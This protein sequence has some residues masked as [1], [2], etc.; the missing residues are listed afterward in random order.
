MIRPNDAIDVYYLNYAIN[1]LSFQRE[2][3]RR[4]LSVAFPQK[5]NKQEIGKSIVDLPSPSEQIQIGNL[6]VLL[7]N[8]IAATQDSIEALGQ[9]KKALLQHL[10][11]QSWR[12]KGYSDPWEKRELGEIF[13]VVTDYVANGSFKSLRQRVSTYSNPNFAY[14]IRL[15]DASNNWKGPWL[16]TDQQS[17]SFLAKTKLH[18]GDILMSN[19]GS[20]GKF[21]LVP[22][23]DR[24]MTL[25]PNAVLL[26]SMTYSTYF[27]FQ[28]LQTSSMT[29]SINEKTTP[30]V[31]QKINKT[32]FK[33]IITNV[34]TLNESSMVGQ[35]LFLLDNLI[36]ATQSRL[37]S[38]ESLKKSLLQDLF[39]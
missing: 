12:F 32:D 37:S 7:D 22:D 31:Q 35:M 38:L 24:P 33:K 18:P 29:E 15:Q 36:A 34:P 23:L 21:F 28:L 9:A 11:D 26:R 13:N 27:L 14:M 5:I 8:L 2:L 1:G 30:G 6:F 3:R 17:Y 10:F 20:V 25:A 19:V 16:Y 39:I 4:T